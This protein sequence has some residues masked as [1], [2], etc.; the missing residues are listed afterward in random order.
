MTIKNAVFWDVAPGRS[1]MNRSFGETY[2]LH[3]QGRKVRERGTSVK[4]WLQRP[5]HAGFSL[6]DFITLKMKAIV[7]PKRR[8]T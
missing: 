4:R 3:L 1:C 7:P 6:A 8:F 5:A 2:G